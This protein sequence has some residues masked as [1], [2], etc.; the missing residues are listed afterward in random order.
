MASPRHFP[1]Y[2]W[3]DE[4][5]EPP[6]GGQGGF[7]VRWGGDGDI[8]TVAI[9]VVAPP[10]VMYCHHVSKSLTVFCMLHVFSLQPQTTGDHQRRLCPR[11]EG[12]G[13]GKPKAWEVARGIAQ[14]PALS[15]VLWCVSRG[16]SRGMRD[17]GR[18]QFSPP[19]SQVPPLSVGTCIHVNVSRKRHRSVDNVGGEG[20]QNN[21]QICLAVHP[22]TFWI[23]RSC[24]K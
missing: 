2:R 9:A 3:I 15:F 19:K 4:P 14:R 12:D 10:D 24:G 11:T 23:D 8:E 7:I 20:P 22:I 17:D 6:G 21:K 5:E 16:C 18:P 13:S 1:P